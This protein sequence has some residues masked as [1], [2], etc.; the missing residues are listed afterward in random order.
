MILIILILV[1][2]IGFPAIIFL[3]YY[4]GKQLQIGIKYVIIF[5]LL[6]FGLAALVE[7]YKLAVVYFLWLVPLI[8]F[9]VLFFKNKMR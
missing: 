3:D 2:L 9:T 8:L 1:G 6:F 7:I 4:K 5:Y